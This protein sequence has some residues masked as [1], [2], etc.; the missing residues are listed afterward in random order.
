MNPRLM[1]LAL[2]KQQL[3]LAAASQRRELGRHLAAWRPAFT[4]ADRARAAG[5]YFLAHPEW[6]AGAALA[7]F[8]LRPRRVLRWLGRGIVLW[9]TL[10]ALRSRL[11]PLFPPHP[12]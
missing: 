6:L 9:R 1:E 7:L 8:L 4:A 5:R 2:K 3:Q 11:A 10:R 12:R